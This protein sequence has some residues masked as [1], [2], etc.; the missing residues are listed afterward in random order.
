M[1][2]VNF[3]AQSLQLLQKGWWVLQMIIII[4]GSPIFTQKKGR[5]LSAFPL[6]SNK[7]QNFN[8]GGIFYATQRENP[9]SMRFGHIRSNQK[10]EISP[11][12]QSQVCNKNGNHCVLKNVV[13][14]LSFIEQQIHWAHYHLLR[15]H[16]ANTGRDTNIHYIKYPFRS[17]CSVKIISWLLSGISPVFLQDSSGS[18]NWSLLSFTKAFQ[19]LIWEYYP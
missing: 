14:Y 17:I 7:G 13:C 16:S 2:P 18:P 12:G 3:P 1:Y 10:E 11:T 15:G 6:H 9:L 8:K 4:S 19:W 5:N